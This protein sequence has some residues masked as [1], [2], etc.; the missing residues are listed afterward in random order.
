MSKRTLVVLA[1]GLALAAF[2]RPGAAQE[3][4]DPEARREEARKL[5][6]KAYE[7][8]KT[9]RH[10]EARRY[11]REAQ[12]LM[13]AVEARRDDLEAGEARVLEMQRELE[14]LRAQAKELAESG[15]DEEARRLEERIAE[16]ERQLERAVRDHERIRIER[17]LRTLRDEIASLRERGRTEEVGK[18]ER[19]ARE[20]ARRLERV[21]REAPR[22]RDPLY[23]KPGTDRRRH[24]Y[25]PRDDRRLD[26]PRDDRPRPY[27]PRDREGGEIERRIHHLRVAAENLGAAGYP[28]RARELLQ[29]AEELERKLRAEGERGPRGVEQRVRELEETVHQLRE[30]VHE[31]RRMV[32][33]IRQHLKTP[34]DQR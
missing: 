18:L 14:R 2:Y 7:L 12:E 13:R 4:P 28:E 6:E 31:L 15:E 16:G 32:E 34:R 25:W 11:I 33:E 5:M 17:R 24:D 20:L 21:G 3:E 1:L 23:R 10:E 19:E 29:S 30:E 9:G 27:G 8:E 26:R 22:P